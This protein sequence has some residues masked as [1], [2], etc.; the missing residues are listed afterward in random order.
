MI[1]SIFAAYICFIFTSP[2]LFSTKLGAIIPNSVEEVM[3]F[4]FFPYM[5]Q[6][7]RKLIK[8]GWEGKLFS[9]AFA[10]YL[11]IGICS[12]F[13]NET[14]PINILLQFLL[15]IKL[16]I[17]ICI[18]WGLPDNFNFNF[19]IEKT[20]KF[21]II[22]SVIFSIPQLLGLSFINTIFTNIDQTSVSQEVFLNIIGITN[23]AYGLF[24]HPGRLAFISAIFFIYYAVVAS[25]QGIKKNIIPLTILAFLLT[26]SQEQ[27]ETIGVIAILMILWFNI[28]RLKNKHYSR[29]DPLLSI[30]LK[31]LT[32]CVIILFAGQI[33]DYLAYITEKFQL[34]NFYNSSIPRITFYKFGIMIANSNFPF[35][36]GLGSFGGHAAV[37]FGSKFY[38]LF[39]LDKLWWFSSGKYLYDNFMAHIIAESGWFGFSSYLLSISSLI[40]LFRRLSLEEPENKIFYMTLS[41][42]FI[43]SLFISLF[44]P[45]FLDIFSI[46]VISFFILLTK[47]RKEKQPIIS[48]NSIPK[49]SSSDLATYQNSST[50]IRD[51]KQ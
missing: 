40:L 42:S 32:F 51:F 36:G 35:G 29:I 7:Y 34:H 49:Q 33:T 27:H 39:G 5:I 22:A 12:A 20:L 23:R 16:P 9:F 48:T 37:K 24:M 11:A 41:L 15:E 6:G 38:D 2:F 46:T 43:F 19:F 13:I 17:I 21:L 4:L 28:F 47:K 10:T 30:S 26:A 14:K 3:L 50:F 25:Q 18:F 45:V 8:T 31:L 1:N 44:T